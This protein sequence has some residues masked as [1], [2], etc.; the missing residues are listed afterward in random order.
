[1]MVITYTD[2]IHG[3]GNRARSGVFD[4][5][6][7]LK[8]IQPSTATAQSVAQAILD[9]AVARDHGR[10]SDDMA[11]VVLNVTEHS[12]APLVRT[13]SMRFPLP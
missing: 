7:W 3:A 10:P 8:D 2:G 11:V 13:I 1:M 6:E 5:A 12:E 9:E 4:V